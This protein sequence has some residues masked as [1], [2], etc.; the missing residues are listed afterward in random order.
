LSVVVNGLLQSAIL[1]K[2]RA[3]RKEGSRIFFVIARLPELGGVGVLENF[4]FES[5]VKP[6]MQLLMLM[7]VMT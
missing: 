3:K 1:A 4:E 6:K 5:T 7:M 2:V